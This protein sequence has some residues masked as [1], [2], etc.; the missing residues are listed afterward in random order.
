MFIQKLTPS[1][2]IHM[3]NLDN[4][5]QGLESPKS[6]NFTGHFYPKK[7][8]PSAKTLYTEDLSNITFNYVGEFKS[9]IET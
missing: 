4:F 1:F 8:T 5:R 3:R 7:N 9:D 2:K 6:W